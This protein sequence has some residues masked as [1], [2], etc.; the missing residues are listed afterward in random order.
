ME[1][2]AAFQPEPAEY[3]NDLASPR[4]VSRQ[5]P[6]VR[7]VLPMLVLACLVPRAMM[8]LRIPSICPDGVLYINIA[9]NI[10]AGQLRA[11]F[12]EMSLNIYP[13]IL[14]A[15]H[16]VGLDWETAATLWGI[17]MSC[18][19]V[20][21]L[22]GWVRRQ[23]DDRVA[24]VAC[25][26]YAIH[27][28]FVEWSPEAM[29]DQTF[30]LLFMLAI[31]WLWRAET[32]VRI[33][34]FTAAGAAICLATVTRIEGLF[35]LVPW[36][37]W[38]FWRWR[39]LG[40]EKIANCK[41]QIANCKMSDTKTLATSHWPLATSSF[42]PHPSCRN[43][44]LLGATLCVVLFPLIVAL[45]NVVWLCGHSGWTTL[46]LNVLG[47][48]HLWLQSMLGGTTVIAGDGI[49][50]SFGVGPMIWVFVPTVI[51][52]LGIV[53]SILMLVGIV[54]RWRLWMRRDHQ[55]LFITSMVLLVAIWVQLWFDKTICPRYS[56]P[57]VLMGSPLAALGFLGAAARLRHLCET[58]WPRIRPASAASG[59]FAVLTAVCIVDAMTCSSHY[60]AA[61]RLAKDLGHCLGRAYEAPPRVVGP[62][63][64]TPIVSYYARS[65]P[66]A[67]LGFDVNDQGILDIVSN[68]QADVVLL[69]P[70]KRLSSG[71]C[72]SLAERMKPWGLEH[73]GHGLPTCPTCKLQVLAKNFPLDLARKPT[74]P[75]SEH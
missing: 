45:V 52:G 20:L 69:R 32:E 27:P 63:D 28:K 65:G 17:A 56:L 43:K 26:L 73:I 68:I 4:P 8:A 57:I 37:L 54:S 16:R 31:Y 24:L 49:D 12:Q 19:V 25:L 30:W 61:R 55:A 23:F 11:A 10:E 36:A 6:K 35:L 47:R 70:W 22:W 75:C 66:Y 14:L 74:A 38:T 41:L 7:W 72:E 50:A 21:P 59:L 13:V 44:L 5:L 18:L 46:R 64:L 71:R 51:K 3:P 9:R 58:R 2:S 34:W 60:F 40:G 29:R 53:F 33:G 62:R 42:I 39:A 67:T 1:L 48:A 15:L